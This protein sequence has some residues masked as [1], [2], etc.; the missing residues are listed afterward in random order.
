MNL[1]SIMLAVPLLVVSLAPVRSEISRFDVLAREQPA[2]QGRVFGDSGAVEKIT[3]RATIALDPADPHNAVIADIDRASRN[4]DSTLF[5]LASGVLYER[6]G[7]LALL[8]M[9]A[10]CLLALPMCAGLCSSQV[11]ACSR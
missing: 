9:A 1:H 7:G 10:L 4:A 5:T 8:V 11:R 3:A 2:L 6:M